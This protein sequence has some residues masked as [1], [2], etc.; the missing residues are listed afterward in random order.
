M[1]ELLAERRL[2]VDHTTIWR[3]VQQYAPELEQR[4]RSH[5]Q[6]TNDS[7]RVNETYVRV[8]GRWVYL[9]RAVD[10]SGATLDFL[11]SEQRDAVAAKRFLEQVLRGENH[12]VPR[13]INTDKHAGYPP[14]I[15][16][17]KE[18]G[19]LPAGCEHRAVEYLNNVIEQDH[20]AIKRR[21]KASGHSRALGGAAAILAGYE[22]MHALRKGQV[23]A[24]PEGDVRAQN[25]FIEELFGVAA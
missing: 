15:Q 8:K 3:W 21:V 4:M 18:E 2:E 25:R 9:Y 1:E 5:R 14:A 11:L 7:W 13:V 10:S 20:R 16:A 12:P 22:A 24:A 17:L 19:V 23:A 6:P